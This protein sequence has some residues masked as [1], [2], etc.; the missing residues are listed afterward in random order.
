MPNWNICEDPYPGPV[1]PEVWNANAPGKFRTQI[2]THGPGLFPEVGQP[3]FNNKGQMLGY[4]V[5]VDYSDF[6][7]TLNTQGQST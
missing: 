7:V 4:V 1:E 5:D 6:T 3:F 2:S